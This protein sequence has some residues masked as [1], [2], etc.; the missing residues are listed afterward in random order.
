VPLPGSATVSVNEELKR[1]KVSMVN[2]RFLSA[3]FP[4]IFRNY[5]EVLLLILVRRNYCWG[6]E[7]CAL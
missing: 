4:Y 1:G 6:Q 7:K 2:K 5:S 3:I